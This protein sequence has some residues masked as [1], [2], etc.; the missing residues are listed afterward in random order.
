[1][2]MNSLP[3]AVD[4]EGDAQPAIP[5]MVNANPTHRALMA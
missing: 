1:M 5:A 2:T 4:G 3:D